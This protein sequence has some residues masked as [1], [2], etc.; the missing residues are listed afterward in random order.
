MKTIIIVGIVTYLFVM[1][2]CKAASN[3]DKQIEKIRKNCP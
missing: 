1:P 3:A 2:F